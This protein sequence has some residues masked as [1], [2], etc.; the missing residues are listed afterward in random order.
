ML[1]VCAASIR[2]A[3]EAVKQDHSP[4]RDKEGVISS[5]AISGQ[6]APVALMTAPISSRA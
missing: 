3:P 2:A 6:Y 1:I 4:L 5:N